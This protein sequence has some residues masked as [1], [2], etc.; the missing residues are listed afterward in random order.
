MT[1][2]VRPDAAEVP[3]GYAGYVGKIR[4]GEDLM[5]VLEAQ[6]DEVRAAFG[7]LPESRGGY[8]YAPGK[9]SIKEVLGHL[10]DVER[11]FCYRALRFGRGDATAVPGFDEDAYA[12]A[13]QADRRTLADLLGEWVDVRRATL[14]FLR[15]LPPESWPRRGIANGKEVSVRALAYAIPG[16]VRHHLEVLADR[17]G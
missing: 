4:P 15:G 17:Y 5:T 2:A 16:H 9:W 13:M 3:S 10:S 1:V 14:S 12:P 6:L 8:R 7:T 11:I